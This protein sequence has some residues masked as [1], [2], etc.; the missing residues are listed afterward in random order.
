MAD[1]AH[2]LEPRFNYHPSDTVVLL[3]GKERQE[4]VVHKDIISA[5]SEF[6]KAALNKK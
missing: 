1:S 6:F 4:M 5:R 3:V 2:P